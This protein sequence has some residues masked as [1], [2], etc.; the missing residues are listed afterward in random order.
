MDAGSS[1]PLI[2]VIALASTAAETRTSLSESIPSL[3]GVLLTGFDVA[4]L[5]VLPGAASLALL[6]RRQLKRHVEVRDRLVGLGRG[7]VRR[8]LGVDGLDDTRVR[9]GRSSVGRRPGRGRRCPADRAA[10]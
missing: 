3:L 8:V 6:S 4:I 5:V 7:R 10:R 1:G 2:A 9:D